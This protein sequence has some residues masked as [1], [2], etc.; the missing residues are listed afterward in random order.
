MII[1]PQLEMTG[2]QQCQG[3]TL[4]LE[5]G[6]TPPGGRGA[7]GW[8]FTPVL[9]LTKVFNQLIMHDGTFQL[10]PPLPPVAGGLLEADCRQARERK[11]AVLFKHVRT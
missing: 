10:S 11:P 7:G 9:C 2:Q 5:S 4:V 3:E 6:V 8:V 1:E